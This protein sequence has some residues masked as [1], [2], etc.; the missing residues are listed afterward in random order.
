MS[1]LTIK[2]NDVNP[3]TNQIENFEQTFEANIDKNIVTYEDENNTKH[4]IEML[5]NELLISSIGTFDV[6]NHYIENQKTKLILK[7]PENNESFSLDIKTTLLEINNDED[8]LIR[9]MYNILENN[10]LVS[11]HDIK[12]KVVK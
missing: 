2:F 4:K 12:I 1:Q 10:E 8:I 3:Q 5:E 9:L 6:K 7:N 11:E